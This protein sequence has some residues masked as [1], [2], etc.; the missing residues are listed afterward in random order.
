MGEER[1]PLC[2]CEPRRADPDCVYCAGCQCAALRYL[3]HCKL[4]R[5]DIVRRWQKIENE[6][7]KRK[8]R[9]RDK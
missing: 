7:R 9:K 6:W 1:H 5:F 2:S 8:G 3:Y 4:C